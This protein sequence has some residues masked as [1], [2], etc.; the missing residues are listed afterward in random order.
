MHAWAVQGYHVVENGVGKAVC[1]DLYKRP[2][3][4]GDPDR[5]D[6]LSS[7]HRAVG[8]TR[9]DARI[10]NSAHACVRAGRGVQYIFYSVFASLLDTYLLTLDLKTERVY[11]DHVLRW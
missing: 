9:S 4:S 5:S 6:K 3:G 2:F 8:R 1:F 7:L 11:V 10:V